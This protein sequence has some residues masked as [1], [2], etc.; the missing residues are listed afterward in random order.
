MQSLPGVQDEQSLES[1]ANEY[2]ADEYTA[3][4]GDEV[5]PFRSLNGCHSDVFT[6]LDVWSFLCV[7]VAMYMFLCDIAG[8]L[9][10][11]LIWNALVCLLSLHNFAA[12]VF[13]SLCMQL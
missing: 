2:G 4:G 1:D 13:G 6:T 8:H 11:Q 5:N 9:P 3:D 7:T 12:M 10:C